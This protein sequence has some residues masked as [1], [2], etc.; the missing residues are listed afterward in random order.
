[1]DNKVIS[2]SMPGSEL[3]EEAQLLLSQA[4]SYEISSPEMYEAA[5]EDLRSIV[6]KKKDLDAQRKKITKPLD[7]AKAAV[8]DLFKPPIDFLTKAEGILKRGLSAWDEEQER[9]RRQKEAEAAE[10]LRK[11]REALEKKAEKM[12]AKGQ[13]EKAAET[14]AQSMSMPTAVVAPEPERAAGISFR[15]NW[16]AEVT[17][18]RALVEA[19]AAGKVP[20]RA[21]EA[22]EKF[23][24]AQAKALREEMNYPGVRV[25]KDRVVAARSSS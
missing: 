23:L 10:A 19:V 15:D 1:M 14:L 4:Q 20:L 2:I 8:M 17:D 9:I 12:A 21:L 3:K 7:E 13:V 18:L 5:A 16:K 24:G 11:E 6:T 22:S 25:Y